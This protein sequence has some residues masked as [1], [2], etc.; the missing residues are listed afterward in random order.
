MLRKYTE[1]EMLSY[2]KRRM[3]LE[4]SGSVGGEKNLTE[5]DRKLLDDIDIWYADLLENAPADRV[6]TEDVATEVSCRYTSENSA[7][8]TLPPRGVRMVSV[9]MA[10]WS[11][12]EVESYSIYS[13]V[14]RLQRNRLTRADTDSPVVLRRPGHLEV[15][16]LRSPLEEG[17]SPRGAFV[18]PVGSTPQLESLTMVVR[19]E[20]GT[21]V[22]DPTLLRRSSLLIH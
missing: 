20:A 3:G 13:D 6:P 15:H 17:I 19:P 16:G 5:L 1:Q 11:S 4:A 18:G 8:I 22:L 7:L 14:A 12:D 9:K 21:Y 2:W 10:D